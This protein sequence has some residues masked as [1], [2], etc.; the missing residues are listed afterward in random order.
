MNK[1]ILISLSV[2]AAVAA[3]AIGGTIAYFSDTETSTG[4]TFTAGAI[5]LKIDNESYLNGIRNPGT[6][7]TLSDLTSQLFFNF[8]DLKPGDWGEDTVS[9]HVYSNDAWACAAIKVTE[10]DDE[11]CTEP[12][13]TDD[14][15]CA[16]PDQDLLDGELAQNLYFFFWADDGDNVYEENERPL[17][18]GPASNLVGSGAVYALADSDENNVGGQT[19]YPLE[20]SHDYYIGKAW[21]F[22]TMEIL[23]SQPGGSNQ[24]TCNGQLVNNAAQTD[25][26][27]GDIQFYAVQARNN[28][29]FQCSAYGP[30]WPTQRTLILENKDPNARWSVIQDQ[31]RG[32]L[33][34]NI[35]GSTFSG[36]FQATGLTAGVEYSL[37][38]YADNQNR[39]VDWGGDNPGALIGTFTAVGGN[40][41]PTPVNQDLGMDLPDPSDWNA[42]PDP[43]YCD[44]NNTFDDY[45]TCVGAKIWLVPSSEYDS[46]TKKLTAW[47][48]ASYL[49]ETDLIHYDDTDI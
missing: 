2:I 45:N 27:M 18:Q 29:E 42:N 31:T 5:D 35:S 4:N 26:V 22:G 20:G 46:A 10:N 33:T 13:M 34:Y 44:Y 15:T 40:I 41:V 3:L 37:I 23:Y 43:N 36:T 17:M 1:K 8:D 12:E 38:Y 39:F 47:N 14:P 11:T 24:I 49:F 30:V 7:W 9:L 48:P 16:E 28:A 25:K 32:I 19:G 6:S 21:C